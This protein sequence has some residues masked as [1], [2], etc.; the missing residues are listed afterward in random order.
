MNP[1]GLDEESKDYLSLY[2]LIVSCPQSEVKFS[3]L[4]TK[5]DEA[6]AMGECDPKQK[7]LTAA[8]IS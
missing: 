4:S 2:L 7:P 3:T 6:K 1:E 5:G 8:V